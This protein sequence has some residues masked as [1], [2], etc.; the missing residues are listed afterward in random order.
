MTDLS[1]DARSV[2]ARARAHATD[3][4]SAEDRA[5]I[6]AK[7][8]PSW[9]A[10]RARHA[11]ASEDAVVSAQRP[12]PR[13]AS[14]LW[15]SLVLWG[16]ALPRTESSSST[17]QV[18]VSTLST[19]PILGA[20]TRVTSPARSS[21]AAQD[22]PRG[23]S[24][25]AASPER[26]ARVASVNSKG[27]SSR[28]ELALPRRRTARDAAVRAHAGLR[29]TRA[30]SLPPSTLDPQLT[31]AAPGAAPASR[32]PAANS[33]NAAL[34]AES[35]RPAVP[36]RAT[37]S[38]TPDSAAQSSDALAADDSTPTQREPDF[39]AQPLDDELEWIGAAQD[40]LR[41][42]Q[43]SA[44]LRLVQE[45]AFR[46]PQGALTPERLALHALA[47][48]ALQRRAAARVVLAE[49]AQRT[50]SSPLLDHVHRNCGL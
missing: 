47:L 28:A 8:D 35:A 10:F 26:T 11:G 25:E 46:F 37:R 43:P 3:G 9:A 14:V 40:A 1:R 29:M 36:G 19:T 16:P 39:V 18:A 2:I 6:R 22:G 13:A 49:L 5:R 21:S 17:A 30:A 20:A 41:N 45:H 38:R 24:Q 42:G 4:P 15:V 32:P 27:I 12:M 23:V 34:R 31:A 33:G 50:T 7:L 48:C 44:V